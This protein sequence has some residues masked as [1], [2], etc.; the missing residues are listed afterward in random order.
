MKNLVVHMSKITS[1][2]T[3]AS[4]KVARLLAQELKCEILERE[5]EALTGAYDNV[6]IVNSPSAFC[7]FLDQLVTVCE[8]SK[9]LI[10]VMQDYTVYPPTQLREYL[11]GAKRKLEL[12]GTLPNLP[13]AYKER[14]SYGNINFKADHVINWNAL[15]YSYRNM[16]KPTKEGIIYWGAFR[17]MPSH[18]T[19]R[20]GDFT[21]YLL[22][23]TVKYPVTISTSAKSIE[24]FQC[25][26]E[27]DLCDVIGPFDDLVTDI[28][29]WP[30]TIYIE[31][32]LSHL[33]FCQPA[34]RFYEALGA[35]IAIFFDRDSVMTMNKAGFYVK[36]KWIVHNATGV[37]ALLPQA[38]SIAIE[39]RAEWEQNYHTD[40][41]SLLN[42]ILTTEGMI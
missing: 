31:D 37:Q 38:S 1:G 30:A 10:W 22:G 32:V 41:I 12:W 14:K 36:D 4:V 18:T 23:S 40:L 21:R 7:G 39:Q 42:T 9:R 13:E 3:Q 25:N 29:A 19:D 6:F 20:W 26:A 15:G 17:V 11:Y 34:N 27:N 8:Q 16:I 33:T 28:Q 35:G 5:N 24:K 2:V